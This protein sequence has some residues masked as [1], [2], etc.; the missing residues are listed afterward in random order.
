MMLYVEW[1][2]L[3]CKQVSLKSFVVSIDYRDYMGSSSK[4]WALRC[5][6]LY[7]CSYNLVGS[8]TLIIAIPSR[9]ATNMCQTC[10]IQLSHHHNHHIW[11]SIFI[12]HHNHCLSLS[13]YDVEASRVSH[14]TGETVIRIDSN[15]LGPELSYSALRSEQLIRPAKW[16]ACVQS[17]Q[18]CWQQYGP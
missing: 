13:Y 11:C 12:N 16:E 5:L 4:I 10:C 6:F 15:Q 8:V 1:C 18:K 9:L 3:G 7:L 14:Y 17:R 2:D